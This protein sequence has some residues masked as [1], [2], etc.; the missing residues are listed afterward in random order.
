MKT[1]RL[2][3]W[4]T[5]LAMLAGCGPRDNDAAGPAEPTHAAEESS[6][7][8][9][10]VSTPEGAASASENLEPADGDWLV[11]QMSAEMEHLNPFTATSGYAH[12]INAF[13]FEGLLERD[14]ATLEFKPALAE[15]W[16]IGDDKMTYTFHLRRDAVFSDGE[17]LTA[18]DVKFTFE[19]IMDPTVD[20]PSLRNYYQDVT[21]CEVVDEYTIRFTCNK[22]YFKHLSMIGGLPVL[23]EHIYGVGDF[24]THPNNRN[25]IGSGPYILER[26]DTGQQVVLA[27]NERYWGE[28]PHILKRVY[29]IIT[30][31]NAAF[32]ELSRHELDI[33]DPVALTEEMWITRASTPKFEAEF[34]KFIY[35]DAGYRYIGWNMRRPL[36]QDKLVR[37]A[38]TML[39]D[40]QAI[41]DN[42]M[43]GLGQV[44]SGNFFVDLPEYD[45]AIKP[46]PFDPVAAGRLL[47]EA[48]WKDTDGDGLRDKGG[49]PFRFELQYTS[50]TEIHNQVA[51]LFQ[52]ELAAAGIE[53]NIRTLEFASLL[54]NVAQHDFD[55]VMMAWGSGGPEPDPY[56]VWHSSMAVE[57]GS[58]H[59]GF[60][61]EEADRIMEE[62]RVEFGRA[63]R[64]EM[65]HRFHAIV[66]EEQPYTFLFVRKA[67]VAVDKRFHNTKVYPLIGMDSREWWVPK[68]LQR[69][70]I[71]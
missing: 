17:P 12:G 48:G 35:N 14:N 59:V 26:W 36:F 24:N 18:G 19:T 49:V 66:H 57:N 39:L 9:E 47:D 71:P 3:T 5:C 6:A 22:P 21:S 58:N 68:P 34:N 43:H 44:T 40:R 46:W 70:Q 67:K 23:P 27:R 53:M 11:A 7:T 61:N 31:S 65:Y 60:V 38:L 64:I 51:T 29:K 15:R 56:Q 54:E 8:A 50:G 41:L 42:L 13:I 62:A 4:A 32:Q 52:E 63:E 20:A 16:E 30:N 25:P 1:Y 28:K 55:A 37:R 2:L 33:M 10:A 45:Q 69:Y